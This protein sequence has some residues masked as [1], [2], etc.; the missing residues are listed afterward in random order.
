[1]T[2]TNIEERH[3]S[4]LKAFND[5]ESLFKATQLALL[6]FK[7]SVLNEYRYCAR[8]LVDFGTAIDDSQRDLALARA[9]VAVSAAYNDLID[10]IVNS[11]KLTVSKLRERYWDVPVGAILENYEYKKITDALKK[12]D[13][14]I[15]DTRRERL[16]RFA[17]YVEFSKTEDFS[18]LIKFA[19]NLIS[20]EYECDSHKIDSTVATRRQNI[21]TLIRTSLAHHDKTRFP[22]FELF[23]QPKFRVDN[24]RNFHVAGAEALIR[25]AVDDSNTLTPNQFL[26][27]IDAANLS[28]QLG[29]WVLDEA[30]HLAKEWRPHLDAKYPDFDLAINI[31]PS[32][33][34]SLDFVPEMRNSLHEAE[35]DHLISIELTENWDSHDGNPIDV[36]SKVRQLGEKTK[37]YI[38]D[39]GTGS[40]KLGYI[41]EI[42]LLHALKIDK[43]IIDGLLARDKNPSE[44]LIQGIVAFAEAHRLKVVAEGVEHD[45]QLNILIDKNI[46]RFQGYN[47]KLSKPMPAHEF[48]N[49]YII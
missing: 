1:M 7:T 2:S 46:H 18:L 42:N 14:V 8:A 37:V 47:K 48:Y 15:A 36:S 32:Q 28:D 20:I 6:D 29:Q 31:A 43:S 25:L 27:D 44:T 45:E 10:F 24:S 33:M 35:V 30:I 23:I 13:I 5:L 9:E 12:A 39:F 21:L 26:N 40:T 38:D 49:K 19:L 17:Q 4:L 3:K 34:A 22:R 41:A 11:I 16:N